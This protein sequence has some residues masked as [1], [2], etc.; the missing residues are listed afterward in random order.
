VLD[1]NTDFGVMSMGEKSHKPKMSLLIQNADFAGEASTMGHGLQMWLQTIWFLAR[2]MRD[3]TVILDEPDVYMHPELQRRLLKLVETRHEQ[4]IVTTHSDELVSST[5]PESILVLDKRN[6]TSQRSAASPSFQRAMNA[7]GRPSNSSLAKMAGEPR[8]ISVDNESL[9]PISIVHEKVKALSDESLFSLP[10][11]G[12]GGWA[13]YH[14][15]IQSGDSVETTFGQGVQAYFILS[16][17]LRHESVIHAARTAARQHS[18][19]QC[20][21]LKLPDVFNY[22]LVPAA[23]QRILVANG[24]STKERTLAAIKA[25][26][27]KMVES[28]RE[29]TIESLAFSWH[30]SGIFASYEASRAAAQERVASA[31][32]AGDGGMSVTR[33]MRLAERLATWSASAFGEEITARTLA[34]A[35][36]PSEIAPELIAVF[37]AINESR[38]F[39]GSSAQRRG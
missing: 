12:E 1:I 11:S 21:V 2:T 16:P 26:L 18:F 33:G 4:S 9:V 17:G 30:D 25:L 3:A 36:L 14:S 28:L 24:A 38:P 6:R 19:V 23:I 20:H 13:C 5:S 34:D 22:L 37:A 29:E 8:F 32:K 10:R 39:G 35:L 31:F 27:R 7:L 15:A